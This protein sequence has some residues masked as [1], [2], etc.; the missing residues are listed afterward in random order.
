MKNIDLKYGNLTG[1]EYFRYVDD[2]L[3][4]LNE[5]S[6]SI[7]KQMIE[8]DIDELGLSI[9]EKRDEGKIEKSFTY[10]G[11][12]INP[13]IIS[14]RESSIIKFEQSLEKLFRDVKKVKQHILNGRSV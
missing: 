2:I 6:F 4:L 8:K 14:V 1:I 5:E 12:N 11:Y 9:N 13:P 10:L 3:I 7:I